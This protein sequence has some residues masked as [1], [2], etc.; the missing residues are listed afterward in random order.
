MQ[1]YAVPTWPRWS[2][3]AVTDIVT[4]TGGCGYSF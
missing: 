2:E 4:S 1:Q 3:V